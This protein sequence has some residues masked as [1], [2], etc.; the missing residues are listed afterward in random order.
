MNF[1][2][3]GKEKKRL[4]PPSVVVRCYFGVD[5]DLLQ[6][7]RMAIPKSNIN[8]LYCVCKRGGGAWELEKLKHCSKYKEGKRL[9]CG[10]P[11]FGSDFNLFNSKISRKEKKRHTYVSWARFIV[12]PRVLSDVVVAWKWGFKIIMWPYW[13]LSLDMTFFIINYPHDNLQASSYAGKYCIWCQAR[14]LW[15][16]AAR[17]VQEKAHFSYI[18]FLYLFFSY[19]DKLKYATL[20][21][22][23]KLL[24]TNQSTFQSFGS[25]GSA[26]TF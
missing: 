18:N 14:V 5:V 26:L 8:H 2:T 13:V 16:T 9:A 3:V 17:P 11:F 25:H 23:R 6:G 4:E 22:S 15:L 12:P 20:S 1:S 21:Y 10:W 7:V 24:N 19:Y